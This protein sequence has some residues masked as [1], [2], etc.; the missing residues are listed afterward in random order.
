MDMLPI[1][2]VFS[3][4]SSSHHFCLIGVATRSG[5]LWNVVRLTFFLTGDVTLVS[6]NWK[7]LAVQ[8]YRLT[9]R[10]D[11]KVQRNATFCTGYKL[12]CVP[13]AAKRQTA[14]A[15]NPNQQHFLQCLRGLTALQWSPMAHFDMFLALLPRNFQHLFLWVQISVFRQGESLL[16]NQL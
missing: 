6:C 12:R 8:T 14:R 3:S 13:L 5:F 7:L 9:Y 16:C 2:T 11:K 15:S 4:T 1:V 10:T